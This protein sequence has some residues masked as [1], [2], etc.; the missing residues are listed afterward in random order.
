LLRARIAE[1]DGCL[2]FDRF[3]ETA[4]YEPGLGYYVAGAKKLGP[5]GD[6]VTAPE[7]SPLFGRCI[8]AQCREAL[9]AVGAGD[10]LELGAGSGALAADVLEA[11]A[12]AD[13]LPGCY[14]IL[15]PSP[16]LAER[17]RA[18]LTARLPALVP[19]VRW[20]AEPPAGFRGVVLANE[21]VDA[22]PVHR[23][24]IGAHGEI[25]EICVALDGDAPIERLRP[26]VSPGLTEAVRRLQ[27]VGLARIPGYRSEINL[28]ADAWLRL[29]A[30]RIEAGLVLL[31]DYG[32]PRGEYYLPERG[33]G[34]L[35]CHYRHRAHAD[36]F[37]HLGLQDI[38][39]HVDFSA[40][41]E[42]GAD[43]GFS[44]AG[45]TT[46]ANFLLGCGLDALVA[47][48]ADDVQTM[49]SLAA[50]AK[51][52][53]LPSAMGERFQV[54]GLARDL[55]PPDGVW[56]GFSVRDLSGRL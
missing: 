43:A 39:A 53:L 13:A 16:D 42:A 15:E 10:I 51:Q 12:G 35:M 45:Y 49:L 3:M 11:L 28:R 38:T 17:Q 33:A 55:S 25:L 6:F 22:M 8:A 48:A 50:G 18:L 31:I 23:F 7:I 14:L 44:L 21:V 20:V 27:A 46:Q 19:R 47:E 5:G 2:P 29:L 41:A 54:L 52:L 56:R 37:I 26:P 32:Y 1:A 30:E 9:A 24:A 36:P 40:L 4:L 34:T